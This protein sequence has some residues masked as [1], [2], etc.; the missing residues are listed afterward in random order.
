M[1]LRSSILLV[2]ALAAGSTLACSSDSG[3]DDGAGAGSGSNACSAAEKRYSDCKPGSVLSINGPCTGSNLQRAECVNSS[4]CA[5]VDKCILSTGSGGAGGATG[6]GGLPGVGGGSAGTP[7]SGGS[8]G[9]PGSGGSA[10]TPGS[11]G[12]AGTPGSGGGNPGC[13][14][15]SGSYVVT[16]TCDITACKVT[17][18]GCTANFEC[19]N[20]AASYTGSVGGNSVTFAGFTGTCQGVLSGDTLMG[21]CTDTLGLATCQYTA[22]R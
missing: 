5:E 19:D 21:T 18:T 10:G 22:K 12:S 20:G 17:Q 9:T 2:F 4:S 14:D 11:G 16:G 13:A 1:T 7:G 15:I 3:G 8:A 6:S